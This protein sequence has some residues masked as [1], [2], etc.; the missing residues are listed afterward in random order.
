MYIICAEG[1]LAAWAMSIKV[2]E[3]LQLTLKKRGEWIVW[4]DSPRGWGLC[5]LRS[6]S[7]VKS[8]P[9]SEQITL[10][11]LDVSDV[12]SERTSMET[13]GRG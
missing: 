8:S 4:V 5:K 9:R 11:G 13:R 7:P 3:K 1:L 2:C 10:C 12:G 6:D